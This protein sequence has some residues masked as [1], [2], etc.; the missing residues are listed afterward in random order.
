MLVAAVSCGDSAT[1]I[2]AEPVAVAD[3]GVED[4]DISGTWLGTLEMPPIPLRIV[5][6]FERSADGTWSGTADSPDQGSFGVPISRVDVTGDRVVVQLLSVDFELRGQVSSDGQTLSAVAEQAGGSIPVTLVRQAGPL[7]YRRPQDPVPPFPYNSADVTFPSETPGVTLAGTLLWP[8][9]PGPF[10]TVVLVTG[11]GAQNRNEELLNHRPFLVL[12]DALARANVAVL[13]YDDRG[14]GEST[15]DFAAATTADFAE[16]ARGAVSFLR[17][18][19]NFPVGAIGLV[20]HSEGGIIAPLVADENADVSF[21]VLLAAPGVE[22]REIILSQGRA[23][24]LAEGLPPAQVDAAEVQQRAV[25]A[26]FEGPEQDPGALDACLRTVL[27]AA[28]LSE[29]EAAPAL[30]D[31]QAPWLRWF[32]TYDPAPV[33]RRTLVPILALNGSLDLQVPASQN[34][35]ALRAAFEAAGNGRATVAELPGLNHLFQH[36]MT[37]SPREYALIEETMAPEVLTQV[38]DWIAALPAAVP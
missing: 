10:T 6:N 4:V 19:P 23:L 29:A 7:D 15:G 37:G 17:S 35:P 8:E 13:R 14:F 12:A 11:S 18:A 33:L 22:G 24:G 27:A 1:V 28:G 32:V 38:A 3:A 21:L 25:Y 34:V 26:C 2:G 5:F 16:D 20:G 30:R 31:L 36:A 9:G